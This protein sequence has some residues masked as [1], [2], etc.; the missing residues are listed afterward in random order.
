ML[1][2]TMERNSM[3]MLATSFNRQQAQRVPGGVVCVGALLLR[4]LLFIGW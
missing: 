1:V 3:I 4:V 2:L